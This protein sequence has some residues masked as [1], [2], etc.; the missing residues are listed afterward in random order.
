MPIKYDFLFQ[1]CG[2]KLPKGLLLYGYPGCGKTYFA[3]AI[4]NELN[5]NYI[6]VKGPELL[7]KYIGISNS[8]TS[9]GASEQ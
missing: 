4:A 1:N 6:S 8:Y 5:I 2:I 3:Q 9:L 7:N